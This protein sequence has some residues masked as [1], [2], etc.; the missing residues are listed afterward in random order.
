MFDNSNYSNQYL[1]TKQ[2]FIKIIYFI[3]L[4]FYTH[5]FFFFFFYFF[6]MLA[7]PRALFLNQYWSIFQSL[8]I[9]LVTLEWD[10]YTEHTVIIIA[11]YLEPVCIRFWRM[12]ASFCFFSSYVHL[13]QNLSWPWIDTPGGTH[14]FSI[15]L[16]LLLGLVQSL[17][18]SHL[19][20]KAYMYFFFIRSSPG[21]SRYFLGLLFD[22][23]RSSYRDWQ[24]MSAHLCI[25]LL[26]QLISDSLV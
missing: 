8:H 22:R 13:I 12:D 14:I 11:E 23:E 1:F 9:D 7:H 4:L 10:H 15:F 19:T 16:C 5:V 6:L 18:R 24:W 25:P 17:Y 2:K 20:T 3:G 21:V 26:W